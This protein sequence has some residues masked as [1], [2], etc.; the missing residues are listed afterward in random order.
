M[1]VLFLAPADLGETVLATGALAHVLGECNDLTVLT[2]ADSRPLFRS[3]PGLKAL[4]TVEASAT[5]AASSSWP[6]AGARAG[7]S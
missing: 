3:V 5:L 4:Y 6:G 2:T 1:A 7:L